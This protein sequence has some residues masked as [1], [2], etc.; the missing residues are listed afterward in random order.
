M[1]K[2]VEPA[3]KSVEPVLKPVEASVYLGE[4]LVGGRDVVCEPAVDVAAQ[5]AEVSAHPL[6]AHAAGCDK[7]S[8]RNPQQHGE[9]FGFH[10]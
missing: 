1:F 4:A 10:S 2:A 7:S 3:F 5:V 6:E 8:E 9:N